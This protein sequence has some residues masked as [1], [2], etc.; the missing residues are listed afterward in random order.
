MSPATA[1]SSAPLVARVAD[2]ALGLTALGWV[3]REVVS[4]RP[5][6][7][8]SATLGC[9]NLVVGM[10]FVLRRPAARVAPALD[11]ALCLVSVPSSGVLLALAPAPELWPWGARGAFLGGAIVAVGSLLILGRSFGVLPA[12]RGLV[13]AGPYRLVRHP[14]YLGELVMVLGCALA[15]RSAAGYA[16]AALA[17]G[18]VIMRIRI[19][20]RLLS[21]SHAYREY[22]ARARFRLLPGLW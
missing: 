22:Q 15:T 20:E 16:T 1:P 19:E 8:V 18:L 5:L 17:L 7:L 11:S 21:Q 9:V 4:A 14:I 13:Q 3:V 2:L 12:I 10:L 6:T